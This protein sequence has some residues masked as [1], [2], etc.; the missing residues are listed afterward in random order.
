[1]SPVPLERGGFWRISN[2]MPSKAS[3]D[4]KV[5]IFPGIEGFVHGFPFGADADVSQP[6]SMILLFFASNAASAEQAT[7]AIATM[8]VEPKTDFADIFSS[9]TGATI[10][11]TP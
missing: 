1:M 7:S 6:H 4:S 5:V 2:P 3:C 11:C 10:Q 8:N 9:P